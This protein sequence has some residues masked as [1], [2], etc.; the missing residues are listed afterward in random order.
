MMPFKMIRPALLAVS[1]SSIF[2]LTSCGQFFYPQN[3]SGGS[4]SSC[5]SCAY[6]ANAGTDDIAAFAITNPLSVASSTNVALGDVPT[7]L[8]VDPKAAYL[9]GGSVSSGIYL[10]PI[11]SGGSLGT[12]VNESGSVGPYAMTVD[13]TGTYLVTASLDENGTFAGCTVTGDVAYVLSVFPIGSSGQLGTGTSYSAGNPPICGSTTS[14]PSSVVVSPDGKH[15]FMA[16]G[17]AGMLGYTFDTSSGVPNYSSG[18]SLFPGSSTSINGVAI[19]PTS[20]FLFIA[21]SGSAGGLAQYKLSNF[22]KVGSTQSPVQTFY[23]VAAPASGTYVYV[24]ARNTGQVYG[25]SY[26][27]TGNLTA[28]SGSPFS[29]SAASSGAVAIASD[30]ASKYILTINSTTGPN[31]QQFSI[32]TNG[33]LTAAST[34]TTSSGTWAPVALAVS[35]S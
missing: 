27:T 12:A 22:T 7:S 2:L 3:G 30:G 6:I 13:P 29:P 11:Q 25:Y 10:L 4:G 17:T 26:S 23:A 24:T 32:G 1:F 28:I 14:P 19:D 8:A 16:A 15:I 9:Y 21:G 31:L 5:T 18:I 33:A 35:G 20:A 34:G